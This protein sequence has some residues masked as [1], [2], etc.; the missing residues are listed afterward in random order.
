MEG[1]PIKTLGRATL[2]YVASESPLSPVLA[3]GGRGN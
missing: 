3:L 1:V 2:T